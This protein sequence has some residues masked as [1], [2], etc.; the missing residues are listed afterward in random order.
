MS[1]YRLVSENSVQQKWVNGELSNFD[2]LMALNTMAGRSYNDLCQY[3][4]MPWIIAQYDKD[5]IDLNDPS[6]YRDLSKPVG[7]LNEERL[8]SFIER[9]ESFKDS[10]IPPFMYGSHYSTMV[11]VVLHF[12]VRLQPFASLHMNIQNGHFDVPDRLFSSI[13]RAWE[14]NTTMLSEVKELTPEWFT[15]PEFL[16]NVNGYEFGKM[17][18]H[19]SVGDVELPPWAASA[20]DFIR[21]NREAL[22]SDYVSAHLHEWIDLIFGY[23]QRGPAAVEAHNVFYYLTYYGA[24]NR[25]IIVDEATRKAIDL[26]IAHFGQCPVE[27]FR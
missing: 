8:Q 1:T 20:E 22:E 10:E 6:V 19:E 23:K 18:S 11:G 26:Q 21:I 24:V 4:V 16:R 9:F 13:P 2:Y 25:D 27:L 5:T 15:L 12:L 17:Q 7:A 3:P 14:H